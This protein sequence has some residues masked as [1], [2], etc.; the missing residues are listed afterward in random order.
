MKETI[1]V[2]Q[3]DINEACLRQDAG[4]YSPSKECPIAQV[5][6]R[7]HPEWRVGGKR[8]RNTVTGDLI[9]LPR[10]AQEFTEAFDNY[11]PVEPVEFEIEY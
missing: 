5:V 6:R 3:A 10:I 4:D 1:R 11:E 2:T 8:I 7:K 9:A